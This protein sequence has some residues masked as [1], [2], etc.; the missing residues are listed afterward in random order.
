MYDTIDGSEHSP[1]RVNGGQR[2]LSPITMMVAP[3][4]HAIDPTEWEDMSYTSRTQIP[5]VIEDEANTILFANIRAITLKH[6]IGNTKWLK[7]K[8]FLLYV[9]VF[10][11]MSL[12]MQGSFLI[13]SASFSQS[14]RKLETMRGLCLFASL[15]HCKEAHASDETANSYALGIHPSIQTC[16]HSSPAWAA[17]L[18]YKMHTLTHQ[19]RI[20]PSAQHAAH[21]CSWFTARFP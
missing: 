13:D 5:V 1:A 21:S 8:E 20:N 12:N 9:G 4:A 11:R 18:P 14:P 2:S 3:T 6:C 16:I 17:Q 15:Y 10:Y 7:M 19:P